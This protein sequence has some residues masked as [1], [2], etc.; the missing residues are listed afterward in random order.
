ME[1]I[2][3]SILIPVYNTEKFLEKCLKSVVNQS[4][5]EIEIIVV[6]DGSKDN[7]LEILQNFA[8]KDKRIIIIDKENGGL[9]TA[10]NAA[11]KIAKGKYCLNIDSDDWIEQGYFE[12]MYERAEKDNLDI[13]ISDIKKW[14]EKRDEIEEIKDLDIGNNDI[15]DNYTYLKELYTRNF[16]NYT[17][18]KMI[19]RELYIKNQIFYDENIFLL[20]DAEVLG[21][22]IYFSKRI[23]KINKSFYCYRIGNNNGCTRNIPFKHLIDILE[24][25]ENLEKFYQENNETEI[26]NLISR[27]KNLMLIRMILEGKFCKFQ[28]YD[29]FLN[30]YL[31]IIKKDKFISLKGIL[32]LKKKRDVL[33]FNFVKLTQSKTVVK[34]LTKKDKIKFL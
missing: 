33:F 16:F 10:R 12:E 5:K 8:Q 28:E 34:I 14:D 7:S 17:C 32:E 27:R 22:L 9:T 13:V 29:S 19:K 11:L 6:N 3:I 26:K 25:F 15:I 20:E 21:R 1:E 30:K 31:E 2:K 4:L 18:N 23:G 24:C